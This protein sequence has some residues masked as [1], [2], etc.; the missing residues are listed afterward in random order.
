MQWVIIVYFVMIARLDITSQEYDRTDVMRATIAIFYQF[1]YDEEYQV[2][3]GS[4]VFDA[5]GYTLKQQTYFGI[6]DM[7]RST[8][9]W[10]VA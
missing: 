1:Y 5:S 9:I 10:Q 8:N 7:R 3:G 6:D 2:N 4:Y